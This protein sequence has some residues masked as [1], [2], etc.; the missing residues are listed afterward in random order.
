M[1]IIKFSIKIMNILRDEMHRFES[2]NC[3]FGVVIDKDCAVK[4]GCV[5]KK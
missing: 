3:T 1:T 2:T 4:Y 5:R